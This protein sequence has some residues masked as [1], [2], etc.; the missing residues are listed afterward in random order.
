MLKKEVSGFFINPKSSTLQQVLGAACSSKLLQTF[1]TPEERILERTEVM[2]ERTEK[3]LARHNSGGEWKSNSS[4][5][6]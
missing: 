3:D 1:V 2:A 6:G 4:I 5:F